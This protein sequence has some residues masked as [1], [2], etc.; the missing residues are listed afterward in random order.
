MLSSKFPVGRGPSAIAVNDQGVWV[1]SKKERSVTRV[2]PSTNG[3]TTIP[4][5][6]TPGGHLLDFVGSLWCDATPGEPLSPLVS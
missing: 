2:D 1:A 5:G 6:N 3:H 4:L